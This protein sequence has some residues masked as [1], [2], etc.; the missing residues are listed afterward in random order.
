MIIVSPYFKREITEPLQDDVLFCGVFDPQT[1]K[2]FP[3]YDEAKNLLYSYGDLSADLEFSRE[4]AGHLLAGAVAYYYQFFDDGKKVS[5]FQ[6]ILKSTAVTENIRNGLNISCLSLQFNLL[7]PQWSSQQNRHLGSLIVNQD[8]RQKLICSKSQL[9]PDTELLFEV[10]DG[11][12]P[13]GI[14]LSRSGVL[15]GQPRMDVSDGHPEQ[16]RFIVEATDGRHSVQKLFTCFLINSNHNL[17]LADPSLSFLAK[18]AC[19]FSDPVPVGFDGDSSGDVVVNIPLNCCFWG[20]S[21]IETK[22][23]SIKLIR[24]IEIGDSIA[25][26][27][28]FSRVLLTFKVPIG[29]RKIYNINGGNLWLTDEH[30]IVGWDGKPYAIRPHITKDGVDVGKLEVGVTIK[31]D[32]GLEIVTEIT[33][34]ACPDHWVYNIITEHSNEFY[35]GGVL[36]NG[37]VPPEKVTSI[38]CSQ[39]REHRAF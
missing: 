32:K 4:T 30:P 8:Y 38:L 21:P 34:K 17:N 22:H 33:E 6:H 1:N 13:P 5:E 23:E 39:E 9:F 11:E 25:S 27:W 20:S 26:P 28:G 18:A 2:C 15:S 31:T 3:D 24:D 7:Q 36:T 16:Y 37:K 19:D 35:V 10:R 14:Q 29:N 12:L